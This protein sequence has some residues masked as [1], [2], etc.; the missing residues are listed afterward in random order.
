MVKGFCLPYLLLIIIT[1]SNINPPLLFFNQ[2]LHQVFFVLN[3]VEFYS[4]EVEFL[5]APVQLTPHFFFTRHV[6][7]SI[8][9]LGMLW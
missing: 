8:W 4:V 2:V 7:A 1:I 6:R 5:I 3:L 9:T